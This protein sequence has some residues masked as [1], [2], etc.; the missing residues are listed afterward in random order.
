MSE[1]ITVTLPDGSTREYADGHDARRGRR[2]DR[3]GA[4]QGRDRRQGRRRVGRPRPP[5]RPRR[6]APDRR[7]RLRR[8]P[9]GAAPLDRARDGRGGHATCS[10]ARSTRSVPRSPTA[11]T[12]TSSSPT[13]A[14]SPRTTSARIEDEMREIV[15]ADQRVRARRAQLRRR[16]RAVRRP[17]VQARDHR[18]GARRRRRRRGRG[19]GRRRRRGVSVYRNVERR[20]RVEF[21]DLCRGPHVPSTGQARRVQAHE[22]RRARTGAATRRARCCNASTAPRGS[23]RTRSTSTCTGSRKPSSATTASSASS[24]TCSRSPRRSVR[25][26]RCSTR[27]AALVRRIMEEYSRQRHEEAGYEFVNSPHIT[28]A[29]AVPDLGPPRLVRR[30]HVPADAPRRGRP[31][32]RGVNYYLK[33]MNCPFHILIYRHRTRSY[34]ELPLRFFEFGSVYRYEKSGVVHGLTRVRGHDPG[35]RAHLLHEGA[36]GRGARVAARLRARPA[37][38][39]RPR[40]LLP[41]AV[42]QA[43]RARRSA[44]TKS[45]TRRPR[46]CATPRSTKDLELVHGR[47]RRRVLRPEDQRAGA[48]TRSAAPGRC[49]RS[50]ST[51]RSR[52]ASTCTTSAPTTSGTGRS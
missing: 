12:T 42:D 29:A 14:R 28:K 48:R 10:R 49:R 16:A 47:G 20:R 40:R 39:L 26:S 30:R 2:V 43:R 52:S 7:P 46:R 18:E 38:R 24:S 34:R 5:A 37:A 23:R 21:I 51:S 9:R 4:R 13:A 17:A 25:G 50:S 19:R 15:K 6:R 36:D 33:P 35:R 44:P 27:R 1:Q 41:R 8:R 45:G 32:R 22:G 3:H 31:G 11:S